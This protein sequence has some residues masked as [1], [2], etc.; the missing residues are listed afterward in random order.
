VEGRFLPLALSTTVYG[1]ALECLGK[2][3]PVLQPAVSSDNEAMLAWLEGALEH[4][5]A[6]RSPELWTYLEAVMYE[7][8]FEMELATGSE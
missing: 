7:L 4:A 1:G 6:R 5:F 2:G 3:M 8:L